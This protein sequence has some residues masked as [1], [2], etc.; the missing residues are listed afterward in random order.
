M[1][2][3]KGAKIPANCF[4]CPLLDFDPN[5]FFCKITGRHF[6]KDEPFDKDR[7]NDCP[8]IGV[9]ESHGRLI[10]AD[11]LLTEFYKMEKSMEDHGREFS[12]SFMSRSNDISTT[13]Y[14]VE[15]IVEDAPTVI[16]SEQGEKRNV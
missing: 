10:D 3:I 14:N 2:A 15:I 8:M 12:F 7:V 6:S 13:W 11:A 16:P 1:I 4:E 5:Y 9:H